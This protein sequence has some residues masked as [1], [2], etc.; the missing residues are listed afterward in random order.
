MESSQTESPRTKRKLTIIKKISMCKL[1][2]DY[3]I[4][5]FLCLWISLLLVSCNQNKEEFGTAQSYDMASSCA[6]DLSSTTQTD[7]LIIRINWNDYQFQSNAQTWHNKIFGS[8]SGQLNEFWHEN[9][10]G[11]SAFRAVL[12]TDATDDGSAND[13][14]ITVSLG[15]NHPNPGN[16]GTFHSY[17]KEA[18]NLAD[19][20]I[21]FSYYDADGDNSLSTTELQ[22]MFLV[23]GYESAYASGA[24]GVWAHKWNVCNYAESVT[25][26]TTDGIS[27]LLCSNGYSRFGELQSTHDATIGII[28]HELGHALPGLPDLYSTDSSNDGIGRHGLMSGGSWGYKTGEYSGATPVHMVAYSKITAGYVSGTA[29]TS[30]ES[31]ISLYSNLTSNFNVIKLSVS[32]TE[33]YLIENREISAT[34]YFT[35]GGILITHI[36]SSQSN[37]NTTSS[38]FIDV[39]EASGTDLDTY[40]GNAGDSDDYWTSG[41]S[42]FIENSKT[43]SNYS[44][45]G[46]T[47]TFNLSL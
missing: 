38:K 40:G 41:N 26:P 13:G 23:A 5:F 43:V 4:L 36:L 3:F 42:S 9:S 45:A 21:D 1:K 16:S 14:I 27:D 37:Q 39:E 47:M 28:A 2:H 18:V 46:S 17:L 12:E 31:S 44:A 24:P 30:S 15:Y 10:L 22:V 11:K 19:S 6:L 34:G 29:K 7:L 8:C 35:T 20:Y 32:S 33:Y 25:I